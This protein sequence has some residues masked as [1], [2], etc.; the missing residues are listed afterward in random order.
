MNI[1]YKIATAAC[2]AAVGIATCACGPEPTVSEAP[3]PGVEVLGDSMLDGV[4]GDVGPFRRVFPPGSAEFDDGWDNVKLVDDTGAGEAV[5]LG[6]GFDEAPE[7]GQPCSGGVDGSVGSAYV[8]ACSAP[9]GA[10]GWTWDAFAVDGSYSIIGDPPA[11]AVTATFDDG[12][13]STAYIQ[14][15]QEQ[16]DAMTV[17][18]CTH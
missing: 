3:A 18:E 4:L 10:G 5:M 17:S 8:W 13:E 16:A 9:S 11:F 6:I 14:L 7:A 2:F 1:V 15:T 12:S